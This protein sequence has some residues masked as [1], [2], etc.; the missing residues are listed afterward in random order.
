MDD[1]QK[2]LFE[3]IRSFQITAPTNAL[4]FEKRLAR[5]NG[6]DY[7]FARRVVE[8]YKRFLFLMLE[9]G[10]PVTPSDQVDQA[11]HLHLLYTRS[12]WD[13]FCVK[14]AGRPLHHGPTQGGQVEG[15]KY[16][17]WYQKTK[18][19]YLELFDE[20]TPQD[21]WPENDIRFGEDINFRRINLSRNLVIRLPN[22]LQ[23]LA[24]RWN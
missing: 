20:T 10:H 3:K 6:W 17:D 1:R 14:I 7:A 2:E 8:Q 13:E 18:D 4:T 23:F 16:S 12:Y 15:D 19:R 5:E 24:N 21:I 22:W 11:W 9:A